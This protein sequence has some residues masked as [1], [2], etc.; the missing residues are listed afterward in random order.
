M[1]SSLSKK[2]KIKLRRL[3]KLEFLFFV[4]LNLHLNSFHSFLGHDQRSWSQPVKQGH[5]GVKGQQ[6]PPPLPPPSS[7]QQPPLPPSEPSK[8]APPPPPM[9]PPSPVTSMKPPKSIFDIDSPP[10]QMPAPKS[11]S[12]SQQSRGHGHHQHQQP[13]HMVQQPPPPPPITSST[14]S[15]PKGKTSRIFNTYRGQ[16]LFDEFF[17]LIPRKR[18]TN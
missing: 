17:E 7:A 5:M 3:P 8:P 12:S 10:A 6:Q 15:Q 18:I 14:L 2:F 1:N 11:H 16:K 4:K 9:Q 13:A